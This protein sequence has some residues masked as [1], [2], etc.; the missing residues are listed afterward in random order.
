[1][2]Y[3]NA[4]FIEENDI[5]LQLASSSFDVHLDEINS[6]L[7]RGAHLILLKVGGHLDFD[8]VTKVIDDHHVTFVAPVPSWIDALSQFLTKTPHA[9][10]RVRQVRWWFSGG[11]QLLSSTVRQF[12]PFVGEQCHILN[13]YGPAEITET[14]TCYEVRRDELS[15]MT[16]IPIGRPLEGY[17][18][19]LLDEYRQPVIPGQ[20]GEIVVGGVGVF[21]G[22]YGRSD[23]TA[24]VLI[25]VNGEKCYATGDFA[26][27]DVKSGELVFI[28]RRDF[29]VK[30][31]GQ[32]IEL[33]A[34]ESVILESS[35]NMMNCVVM[36]E[37]FDND[38]YLSAYMKVKEEK[39]SIRD[40]IIKICSCRLPSYMVPSKWFFVSEFPLNA[41][42]KIDRLKLS[43]TAK[44]I[45]SESQSRSETMLSP[46]EK[47]LEDIFVRAFH[48]DASPDVEVSFGQLGGTS[49]GAMHALIIIREEVFEKMDISLLFANPSIR[50]LA[51]AL[52]PLLADV[53][54]IREKREDDEDFS[55]RPCSS[56]LIETLGILL[57]AW[58]WLWPIYIASR[59]QFHFL[60]ILLVPLMHLLQYPMFMKLLGGPFPR[61]RDTLYSSRY[62]RIWFLRRQWS[63]NTYWLGQLLGTPFY[64]AYLRL[65]GARISNEAHIYTHQIDAPWLIKIG[66]ATYIGQEVVLSSLTYHDCI[67]DLYEI[68]IGSYCSIETRCVLHDRVDMHDGV[69]VE[70]LTALTGRILGNDVEIK[71]PRSSIRGQSIVQFIAIL[72]MAIFHA[73]ILKLSWLVMPW[74]PLYLILPLCWLIWSILGAIISLLLLRFVVDNVEQNFSHPLNSWQFLRRFWLRHLVLR[75]FGP[76][77]STVFDGLNSFTPLIL[78]WLGATIEMRNIEIVDFVPL[79][80]VPSNL[81]TIKSDVTITSEIC[82]VPYDVTIHGQCVV[83]GPIQINRRSFLGNN[84]VLRSGVSVPEDVLISSLTRVDQTT[85]ISKKS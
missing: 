16:S 9:Q 28:G 53:E 12:L 11:E 15:T 46:L 38:G 26:R 20:Q 65:C 43:D 24:E 64:N 19:Y 68:R 77:L 23:L 83:A 66:N 8:Y 69:F 76:C 10:N 18:V 58:Q 41:N 49:L 79:L 45:D 6:A 73:F 52:E 37:G 70:P 3:M 59:L 63:L 40:E 34:I 61:G 17:H 27:L 4:H 35:S 47:K 33:S 36:K 55:I 32:R 2:S 57:L 25:D 48:L 71:L 29:Q 54:S 84:C 5:I 1:M 39:N 60:Q 82:F 44:S 22:Y 74:L 78:R 31:R 14:A 80:E 30:L 56:W 42:G 85:I 50:Q 72:A 67:Y 13:S 81:L 51:T 21:A 75:S 7:V 62:Y